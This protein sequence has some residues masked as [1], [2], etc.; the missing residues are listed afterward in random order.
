MELLK[1]PLV[2]GGHVVDTEDLGDIASPT[3]Q[4]KPR[5][6]PD[7]QPI[8]MITGAEET[9]VLIKLMPA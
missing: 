4:A 2:A 6:L 1:A 8:L 3:A 5:P 9:K 7:D